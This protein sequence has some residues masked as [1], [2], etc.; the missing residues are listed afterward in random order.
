[1]GTLHR[2]LACMAVLWAGGWAAGAPPLEVGDQAPAL[3]VA[4][5]LK[6]EPIDAFEPGQVYV[7]SFWASWCS[8]CVDA[9][10]E[11][12]RVQ[13]TFADKGVTVI[14][15]NVMDDPDS[16]KAFMTRPGKYRPGDEM[17]CYTVLVESK[18]PGTDPRRTGAMTESWLRATGQND[19]P[20]AFIVDRA[21]RIAWIGHPT[22]PAGE[23]DE[24]LSAV[25]DDALTPD[26]AAA[27]REK[28]A[29]IADLSTSISARSKAGDYEGA[30]EA[31][32]EVV[33]LSPV[34]RRTLGVPKFEILL[35][36]ID[37][38]DRAYAFARQATQHELADDAWR[39]NMMAWMIV[40]DARVERRDYELATAIA[41]RACDLSNWT[42]PAILDTLAKA[43]YDAGD[44]KRGLELQRQA[45][46]YAK[47]TMWW[48]ELNERLERYE[49]EGAATRH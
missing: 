26:R 45:V 8:K 18:I 12:S 40:D 30:L 24:Y 6:G 34:A 35:V 3:C 25:A 31:I 11:L 13:K 47:D 9:M 38:P 33:A 15:A 39:L 42:D 27:L 37:D 48:D 2:I 17:M 43:Y 36:G 1:M 16:A 32:D 4:E 29:H 44:H 41:T 28:W 49:R 23:L 10:P 7:V 5:V 22:W 19:I 14:G 20:K 21:G 46:K